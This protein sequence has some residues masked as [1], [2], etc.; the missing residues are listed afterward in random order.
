MQTLS[1]WP[2]Q[3]YTFNWAA[4]SAHQDELKRVCHDLEDKNHVSN[5]SNS[6]KQGL[7]ESAFDFASTDNAS[8]LAWSHW[9]KECIF[10]SARHAN[11]AYWK[12]GSNITIEIHESWCHITRDGG[13]HD[14]HIHPNSS[15][16]GIYYLD[17]GDMDI[18]TKN[19]VNRFYNPTKPAYTDAG[20]PWATSNSNVDISAQPGMLVIFPSWIDH[21]AMPYRGTNNR[22]ILSFNSQIRLVK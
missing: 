20:T 12:A 22:Y 16:S 10:K 17:C 5:V 8:V 19:G 4:H 6:I 3:M 11:S 9:V 1:L 2:V 15:W 21:S 7:Y 13:Y 14:N 18:E